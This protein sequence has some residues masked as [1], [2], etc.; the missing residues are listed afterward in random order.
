ML[1]LQTLLLVIVEKF[2]FKIPRIAQKVERFYKNIVEESFFGKDPNVTE[3]L[4]D[5]KTSTEVISRQ[6]QRNEICISLKRGSMIHHVYLAKNFAE[7]IIVCIFL[8]LNLSYAISAEQSSGGHKCSIGIHAFPSLRDL[9][10]REVVFQ[11]RAKKLS[12]FITLLYIQSL[13]L[14][15]HGLLSVGAI[16]WCF[17]F[18]AI[19]NLLGKIEA[20]RSAWETDLAN[21]DGV[22]GGGG[23]DFLFLF[24]LLAH[25]CGLEA[26]LRVLTHSDD[27]F[28][29]ICKPNTPKI[30]VLEEDKLKISWRPADLEKWMRDEGRQIPRGQK[31]INL[32]SYEV[33]IFPTETV[34]HTRTLPVK[35]ATGYEHEDDADDYSAWFFDLDGGKTEYTITIACVIGRSRMKGYKE[36]TNLVPYGPERPRNGILEKAETNRF[37]LFWDPPKGEFTKY[38]LSIDKFT[39]P[40]K[41]LE[42]KSN[43]AV[44][45]R[46]Q[47]SIPFH[48]QFS[49]ETLV[50]EDSGSAVNINPQPR[51]IE[52]LSSKL[53]KYTVLGLDPGECYSVELGTKTGNVCTRQCIQE[54]IMTRPLSVESLVPVDVTPHSCTIH[55]LPLAGHSCLKG[56]QVEVK[57][58]E[59]KEFKKFALQKTKKSFQLDSMDPATDYDVSVV[60]LCVSKAGVKEESDRAKTSF[61]TL[62]DPV[63]N[64]RMEHSTPNSILVKWDA[65]PIPSSHVPRSKLKLSITCLGPVEHSHSVEVAADKTQ[66]NFSKLPDPEGSGQQYQIDVVCLVTTT[67][68]SNVVSKSSS[69]VFYTLPLKPSGL[70]VRRDGSEKKIAWS[71]SPTPSVTSYKVRWRVMEEGQKTEEKT[72]G[73]KNLG[74]ENDFEFQPGLATDNIYKVN[75]YAIVE[76]GDSE[77]QVLESKE[78][79]EKFIVRGDKLEVYKEETRAT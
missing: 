49:E 33:T 58:G 18:R 9:E 40:A 5:P 70:K 75:V 74:E 35:R 8:P 17:K 31:P 38:M 42:S 32:E 37:D 64:L 12:F 57:S 60:S 65:S 20:M 59:G 47:S 27:N 3:D 24:D 11:C 19:S 48:F 25:N 22:G 30:S 79:H 6:R 66:Y 63:K 62:P 1:L 61:T 43:A 46:N 77:G 67:R 50:S 52:N 69:A 28:H 23:M 14:L 29:E 4:T 10:E 36:V 7:I 39:P 68:E 51:R 54:L 15:F 55:W 72:V 45:A 56:F 34:N 53:T 2:S 71:A 16:V 76:P 21:E 78:L 13:L 26:T 41:E 44:I 73:A